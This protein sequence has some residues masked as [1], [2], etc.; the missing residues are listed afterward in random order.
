MAVKDRRPPGARGAQRRTRHSE[1]G[2]SPPR[3]PPTLGRKAR[4]RLMH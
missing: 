2:L 3:H 4:N 1:T